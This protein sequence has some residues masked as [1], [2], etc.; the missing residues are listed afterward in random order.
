MNLPKKCKDCKSKIDKYSFRAMWNKE[1]KAVEY[2]C[3]SCAN[4]RNPKNN[5]IV[6]SK[7]NRR[8]RMWLQNKLDMTKNESTWHDDIKGR[9]VM[10]DGSVARFNRD[11]KRIR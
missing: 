4:R 7:G 10:P 3:V 2:F 11:G 9:K 5:A 6:D 8:D 1:S